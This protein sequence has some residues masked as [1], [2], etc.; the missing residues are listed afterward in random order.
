MLKKNMIQE[1]Q[2]L[3]ATGYS[4][5][6]VVDHY[7]QKGKGPSR[8]TIRKYYNMEG[9]PEDQGALLKKE[10]AFDREPFREEIIEIMLKNPNCYIS[11]VY[12]L[13]TERYVD[14]GL[15][16]ALPGNPQTLRNFVGHLRSSGA[17]ALHE[18]KRRT[19]DIVN[20][21][22]PGHQLLIDFGEQDIGGGRTV[23]FICLL[24]RYSRLIG[25]YAQDHHFNA[26]EAASAIYRFL[27]KIGGRPR[28]LVIDQDSVFVASEAFG[29]I[30]ETREFRSFLNEQDLRLWVCNR[31]D[32]ESKGPIENV[33][34]YVK[35]SY[36]SAR[37]LSSVEEAKATLPG[38]CE[39][40]NR[41]IH[42]TTF[43]VPRD[44]FL[45]TEK[46]ALAPLVPSVYERAPLELTAQSINSQPFLSYRSN[47][48][49]LP[50]ECCFTQVFYRAV[51]ESLHIYGKDR[52][53]LCTHA[54]SPLKGQVIRLPEHDREPSTEWV[55]IVER[56]R[57]KYNCLKFQHLINGFKKE[58]GRHLARQLL[59]LERF[60]DEEGPTRDLVSETF[61]VCCEYYRYKFSQF[62]TAYELVKARRAGPAALEMSDV[63]KRGLEGYQEAFSLRC[64][65]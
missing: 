61:E 63:E 11:S 35:S 37:S 47:K 38:W 18:A 46:A 51:K 34:K 48:Y 42:Q 20:D 32:P 23:H 50:W 56:L 30:I 16:A 64:V 33:V 9:V 40:A 62:K 54:I 53:H 49:S 43:K 41:R 1:I 14:T 29:E 24:L 3:K 31:A 5:S 21:T 45:N 12:D 26:A 28:E 4:F 10:M 57:S 27:Q 15:Y 60:L 7:E 19:Y 22:P 52:R 8:P 13:L 59:A 58:N 25:V 44:E 65:G 17:I 2:D 55:V 36:F 39:R 6:E